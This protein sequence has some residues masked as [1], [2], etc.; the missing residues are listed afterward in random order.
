MYLQSA[1]PYPFISLKPEAWEYFWHQTPYALGALVTSL[2]AFTLFFI[3]LRLAYKHEKRN[4]YLSFAMLCL[5]Y[6]AFAMIF[7]LRAVMQL[8]PPKLGAQEVKSNLLTLNNAFTYI[9]V[10]LAPGA[11]HLAYYI[12]EKRYKIINYVT[13][14]IWVGV[15]LTYISLFNG[16]AFNNRWLIYPFGSYPLPK[17]GMTFWTIAAAAGYLFV[18]IPI[19]I[20]YIRAADT[21]PNLTLII[22]Y[23]AMVLLSFSNVP[24]F[25]GIGFYPGINFGF[26]PLLV[27]AFHIFRS[28]FKDYLDLLIA[29]KMLFYLFVSI[30]CVTIFSVFIFVNY[31]LTDK[32]YVKPNFLSKAGFLSIS[33]LL[34]FVLAMLTLVSGRNRFFHVTAGGILSCWGLYLIGAAANYLELSPIIQK[35]LSQV[36]FAMVAIMPMAHLRL[37]WRL[38]GGIQ[39]K[40][41]IITDVISAIFLVTAFTAFALDAYIPYSFANIPYISISYGLLL[42]FLLLVHLYIGRHWFAEFETGKPEN[43]LLM[44]LLIMT[45]LQLLQMIPAIGLETFPWGYLVLLPAII[46][47]FGLFKSKL[48]SFWNKTLK[49]YLVHVV[50]ILIFLIT[51]ILSTLTGSTWKETAFEALPLLIFLLCIAALLTA[52]S[53]RPQKK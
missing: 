2:V 7:A 44:S 38:L 27:M 6:G 9:L 51:F 23:N 25:M 50:F 46:M 5:G 30:V 31:G 1:K 40:H 15:I 14:V 24:N 21:K 48:F 13:M 52:L 32:F 33:A 20:K 3:A 49:S 35:R 29:H 34:V 17:Y 41:V 19:F 42:A 36:S 4:E 45:F 47:A 43:F 37:A 12:T 53:E 16:T 22:A 39:R 26:I 10:Y 8:P 18:L 11:G 28:H